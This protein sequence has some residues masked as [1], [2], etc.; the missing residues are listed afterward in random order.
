MR[1]NQVASAGAVTGFGVEWSQA[2]Y[3]HIEQ[4]TGTLSAIVEVDGM[5]AV[6]AQIAYVAATHVYWAISERAGR[7]YFETSSDGVAFTPF[8]ELA[9]PFD[10]SLVAPTMYTGT[11]S[12][13]PA[14]GQAVFSSFNGGSATSQSACPA[15]DLVDTFDDGAIGHLWEN[16]FADP[17]CQ[18]TEPDGHLELFDNGQSGFVA[19]RSSAAYDLRNSS[20]EVMTTGP[21]SNTTFTGY[22]EAIADAD[23]Y[24]ELLVR[25]T[26]Y[27]TV[28]D[29]ATNKASNTQARETTDKYI[30]IRETNGTVF[31]EASADK[32]TWR[33][34]DSVAD[35]IDLSNLSIGL[36]GGRSGGA[37]Q[38]FNTIELDDFNVP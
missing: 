20:I 10:V 7:I 9:A 6:T 15:T 17:C 34:L 26:G 33:V 32:I 21:D 18:D 5:I 2:A 3:L 36:E 31:Y 24:V 14:P 30:R 22:L 13:I 1:V 11:N 35:P 25:A 19:R 38:T 23:N 4:A 8:Y 28:R 12:A 37:V 29:V 27:Q 16:S